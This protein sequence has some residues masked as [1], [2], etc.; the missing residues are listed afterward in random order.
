MTRTHATRNTLLG[1]FALAFALGCTVPADRA[2]QVLHGAGYTDVNLKGRAWF[3]CSD[4]D[5][6]ATRFA[7]KGPTGQRVGGAVCCGM[8]AKNCTIRLD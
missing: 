7:A 5:T 6:L 8:L 4:D 1:A 3:A 2:T